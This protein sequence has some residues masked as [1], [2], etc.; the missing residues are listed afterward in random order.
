MVNAII[1]TILVFYNSYSLHKL[2][3]EN[4]NKNFLTQIQNNIDVKLEVVEGMLEQLKVNEYA[5]KYARD[6]GADRF[7]VL[8]FMDEINKTCS[9]LSKF[10]FHLGITTPNSNLVITPEYTVDRTDYHSELFIDR[11]ELDRLQEFLYSKT[12]N[13]N[14]KEI[15]VAKEHNS[16]FLFTIIQKKAIDQFSE[17]I[18]FIS[19]YENY[20]LPGNFL[21]GNESLGLLAD[22]KLILQSNTSNEIRQILSSPQKLAAEISE[23][24]GTDR[25]TVKYDDHILYFNPSGVMDWQY[26]YITPIETMSGIFRELLFNSL[27]L[28]FFLSAISLLIAYGVANLTYTPVKNITKLFD[29]IWGAEDEDEFM[30]IRD[31]AVS[32]DRTNQRLREIIKNNKSDLKQK[33]LRDLV[34]GNIAR[35]VTTENTRKFNLHRLEPNPAVV[36]FEISNY[37][38]LENEYSK[39][40]IIEVKGQIITMICSLLEDKIPHEPLEINSSRFV[41]IYPGEKGE[42]L[43]HILM[44]ALKSIDTDF[45]VV[46][47]MGYQAGHLIDLE[48]SYNDALNILE[49]KHIRTVKGV[50][51]HDDI[52]DI[53]NETYYYPIDTEREIMSSVIRG[54][55]DD[56][57]H[58]IEKIMT[59]N[60]DNREINDETLSQ[61]IFGIISTINR[62]LQQVNLTSSAII[63]ENQSLYLSLAE[64]KQREN[65]KKEV[66]NLFL[67]VT[68]KIAESNGKNDSL[69]EEMI[70]YVK[71]N[72]TWDISLDD[73]ADN[74][75]LTPAYMSVLFKKY[76]GQNFK[77]FLNAYR[78]NTAKKLLDENRGIK[79]KDLAAEVGFNN[80]NSFIRVFNKYVGVS[81]GHYAK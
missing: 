37:H 49:Y 25:S 2:S 16:P 68:D 70:D 23:A 20:F 65:L 40:T 53:R 45:E 72:Y 31:T 51:T 9:A 36:L 74:F 14:K 35:P 47:A 15:F 66:T 48:S 59:E 8:R 55:K 33:F 43:K 73:M 11:S 41:F 79:V 80:T 42:E 12:K 19:F 3:L 78:I 24:S 81:P 7:V 60:M 63:G 52:A 18:F 44:K 17:L 1:V 71:E 30:T 4:K 27:I 32:I 6:G 38:D 77:E 5:V 62:I 39:K 64:H 28:Y 21:N 58:L 10:G 34:F 54:K 56:V 50:I 61:F 29:K 76:T 69:G 26:F 46:A 67:L 13:Y 22:S 57:I 75:N